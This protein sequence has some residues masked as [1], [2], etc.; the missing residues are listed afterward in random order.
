VNRGGEGARPRWWQPTVPAAAI[1]ARGRWSS[2]GR[3]FREGKRR[4]GG[5]GAFS[6]ALGGRGRGAG[7]EGLG[8]RGGAGDGRRGH[9]EEGVPEVGDDPDRWV[10]PVGGRERGR[11]EADWAARWD[12]PVGPRWEG[13]REGNG[14][15]VEFG[16]YLF[17]IFF[18]FFFFKSFSN[19]FQTFF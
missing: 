4:G 5:G 15:W 7:E 14:P 8:T 6:A 1:K 18:L 2:V 13:G 10:P 17:F 16:V 3:R 9:G 12:G 19:L 11:L